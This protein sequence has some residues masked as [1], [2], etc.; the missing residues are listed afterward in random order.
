MDVS[1]NSEHLL[2]KA[3][4]LE[5]ESNISEY[6]FYICFHRLWP[7]LNPIDDFDA[8]DRIDGRICARMWKVFLREGQQQKSHPSRNLISEQTKQTD[9]EI[10]TVIFGDELTMLQ[11]L[12]VI[13]KVRGAFASVNTIKILT[14]W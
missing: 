13:R 6:S 10:V 3:V 14:N 11:F 7:I 1:K 5:C 8:D 4:F 12:K 9:T 2:L